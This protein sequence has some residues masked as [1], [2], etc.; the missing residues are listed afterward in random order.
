MMVL[1]TRNA[2]WLNISKRKT[3]LLLVTC[4]LVLITNMVVFY[5]YAD[6]GI[7][8]ENRIPRYSLRVLSVLLFL[9]YKYVLNKPFQQHL[10]TN[11]ELEPLFK[12]ALFWVI[13]GGIPELVI[14]G[15]ILQ[16]TGW[17]W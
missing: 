16:F 5:M 4:V 9:L 2:K 11:G 3:Y 8:Q 6:G 12:P 1:G 7:A 17:A 15:L 10:L 14:I 13:L